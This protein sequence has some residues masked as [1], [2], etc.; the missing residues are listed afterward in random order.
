MQTYGTPYR[1]QVPRVLLVDDRKAKRL[2]RATVMGRVGMQVTCAATARE[3]I[4]MAAKAPYDLVLISLPHDNVGSLSLKVEIQSKR[5][6][7]RVAFLVGSPE[8]LA[9]D[10]LADGEGASRPIEADDESYQQLMARACH[11]ESGR[12]AEAM[13][14]ISSLRAL[15]DNRKRIQPDPE[16]ERELRELSF[17]A[18]IRA[19]ER[20]AG[21]KDAPA[22]L[23]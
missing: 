4:A 3:A 9:G 1:R 17:A 23:G 13:A 12:F 6:E 15:H 19:E 22:P 21:V 7:Q 8:F 2:L 5:P 20:K 11:A 16:R 14:R 18:A 10:P